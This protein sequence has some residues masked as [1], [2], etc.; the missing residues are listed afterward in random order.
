[1]KLRVSVTVDPD[2]GDDDVFG[3]REEQQE[4]EGGM[5][6]RG[7][8]LFSSHG[9]GG[10]L[11]DELGE[12]EEGKGEGRGATGSKEREADLESSVSSKKGESAVH[13][14]SFPL[15]MC[16]C[17]QCLIQFVIGELT[18]T[19]RH[20]ICMTFSRVSVEQPVC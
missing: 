14:S 3:E 12:E 18:C 16:I 8:G 5:F 7:D 2:A 11:F 17:T 10:G 13:S 19:C 9:G 15:Q 4:D 1:M 20:R 6:G